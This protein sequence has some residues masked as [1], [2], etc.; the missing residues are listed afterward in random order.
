[1]L[2]CIRVHPDMTILK[3]ILER[4]TGRRHV[5]VRQLADDL[6]SD[7]GKRRLE[8]ERLEEA[9]I[10]RKAWENPAVQ[11]LAVETGLT[12]EHVADVY[13]RL[14]LHGDLRMARRAINNASLLRWY[15]KHGGKDKRLGPDEAIQLFMFARDGKLE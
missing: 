13:C 3:S 14:L 6:F 10:V 11:Q 8:R 7:E 12:E 2:A 9:K 4:L 15:Y 1:M 5:Y